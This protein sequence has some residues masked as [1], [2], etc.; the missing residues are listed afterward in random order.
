MAPFH[1]RTRQV[2]RWSGRET[3]WPSPPRSPDGMAAATPAERLVN[4]SLQAA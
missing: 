3:A 2:R 4:A 1:E